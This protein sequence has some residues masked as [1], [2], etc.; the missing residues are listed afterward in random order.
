[1]ALLFG[2][3]LV[4]IVSIA[5]PVSAAVAILNFSFKYVGIVVGDLPEGGRL[6]RVRIVL[7][8][9]RSR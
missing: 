3:K 4:P 9:R 7:L 8:T 1:M 5:N 2:S 6:L